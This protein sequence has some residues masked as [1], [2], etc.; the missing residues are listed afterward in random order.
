MSPHAF[1]SG[2]IEGFY[3]PPW[4]QGE[5]AQLFGWMHAWGLNTYVYA[6]KDDLKHRALWRETYTADEAEKL[7]ANLRACREGGIAFIYA[8]GPGLDFRYGDAAE[9]AAICRRFEQLLALGGEH[10]ALLFDDIPDRIESPAVAQSAIANAVFRWLRE[11]CASASLAFCPTPYCGRMVRSGVGGAGYLETIGRELA[12]EIDI[13]WTGPGIVS[14][15]I[16]VAHVRDLA[17]RL[18]RPPLIWDNL[19][20]NDYDGRRFFVG[21]YSGRAPELRGEVRGLLVNPNSEFPLNFVPLR[22][23]ANFVGVPE[24]A[25]WDARAAY[26]AALREWWPCFATVTSAAGAPLTW[27]DFVLFCDCY[28]LPHEEG[29]EAEAFFRELHA[30]IEAKTER[31][32][33]DLR[34]ARPDAPPPTARPEVGP[35]LSRLAGLKIFCA[36]LAELRDRPLFYALHRRAWELREELDLLDRYLASTA[37]AVAS[38]SHLPGTYRGGFVPRLQ[39]LLA[40]RADGTFSPSPP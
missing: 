16:S 17:Q 2:I 24:S 33:A 21:P 10:F 39:Q 13:F 30:A 29:A 11:R 31:V 18:C 28:Y 3:G 9:T 7:A 22:T 26:L 34:A 35:Y 4:S 27:D 6:P 19:H 5:R 1:R 25:R 8:L 12:P 20:A 23:F 36:R 37:T 15:E 38:D 32:G 40:P 14:R